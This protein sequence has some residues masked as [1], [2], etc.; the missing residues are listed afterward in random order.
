MKDNKVV[1]LSDIQHILLRPFMYIGSIDETETEEYLLNNEGK[2]ELTKVSYVPGLMKIINEII[3]NSIDEAIRTKFEYANK[4]R[5]EITDNSVE[6]EDNG[7][8]IPVEI[9]KGTDEYMPVVA[10]THPRAGANFNDE[11]RDTIG[12]NGIGS[13]A[14]NV[15]SKLFKVKT[16]DGKKVLYLKCQD[17]LS[18]HDFTVN[19]SDKKFT[20]VYFEP[21][22]QRFKLTKIN[23]SIKAIVKQRLSY[24]SLVYPDIHFTF[25]GEKIRFKN[26]KEF[27]KA[28]NEE[29]EM[30]E[31]DNYFIAILPN[32]YDDFKFFSLVNGLYMKSGGTHIDAII[33]NISGKLRDKI[34]AKN[35]EWN[36]LPGDV[37]NKLFTLIIMNNYN[38]MKFDS[39]T[40]EKLTNSW[41]EVKAYLNTGTSTEKSFDDFINTKEYAS[42][43]DKI[44]KNE[45]ITFPIVETFKIKEEFR[46]RKELKGLLKNSG[47]RIDVEK[48]L[49]PIGEKKY[50]VLG[51]GDSAVGGISRILGRKGFGYYTLKGKPLNAFE[52]STGKLLENKEFTEIIKILELDLQEKDSEMSY[53]GVLIASDQD[54]DGIHIRGL[55]LTFFY[56]YVP[57]LLKEGRIRFL[58]TPMIILFNKNKTPYKYFFDFDNYNDFKSKND[59]DKYE[60]TYYKGL[61]TF[62]GDELKG[63]IEKEGLDKFI[64]TF[65]VDENTERLIKEWMSKETSD[66][67][68]E[69][70]RGRMFD[71]FKL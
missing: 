44:Y 52:I 21:D 13:V 60:I 51:E 7:R 11:D 68:K 14:T 53:E 15:F 17:N 30:Y 8:G 5:I 24:L 39:Q 10:F 42:F 43:I 35:K 37:K 29:Y 38:N 28:F 20:R 33:G 19:D 69:Y 65:E 61:G 47:K 34:K 32:K 18:K 22:L 16:S 70:L 57:H 58:N 6:V 48:Y 23:D 25:N 26:K 41:G 67:R 66:K 46:K 40:K 56:K 71:L 64:Q 9:I 63:I 59:I 12:M 27:V 31:D 49:P 55:L 45:A 3:D 54:L 50:L 4:I 62:E 1:K 2:Y 36:V